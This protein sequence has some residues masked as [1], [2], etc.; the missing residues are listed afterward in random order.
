M[1]ATSADFK[2]SL[3]SVFESGHKDESTP[4]SLIADAIAK[5]FMGVKIGGL[6]VPASPPTEALMKTAAETALAGMNTPGQFADKLS[7]AINAAAEKA[8]VDTLAAA[9]VAGVVGDAPTF[10]FTEG[11]SPSDAATHIKSTTDDTVTTW[12]GTPTAGGAAAPWS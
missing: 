9:T 4:K 1:P 11:T 7:A 2:S 3:Q 6:A 12:T 10:S 8:I 5:Y